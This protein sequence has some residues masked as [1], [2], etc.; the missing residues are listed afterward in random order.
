MLGRVR[1]ASVLVLA[2]V[3]GVCTSSIHIAAATPTGLVAAYSFDDGSGATAAD[4]SGNGNAAT[5]SGATWSPSGQ[6]GGAAQLNGTSALVRV[7][8]STSLDLSTGM[9]LEA[10]V[11]PTS[12]SASQT[13][14]AKE[15]AGGGFPYGLELDTVSPLPMRT[16]GRSAARVGRAPCRRTRGPSS[17][18]PSTAR[19]CASTSAPRSWRASRGADR[20]RSRT[21]GS[22][23]AAT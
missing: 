14:I 20:W 7:A 11:R 5:L 1:L 10:W 12:F 16:R 23:S 19:R 21:A 13:L 3:A 22:R 4:L 18:R 6:Y 9:T 17:P 15:R 2:A 8:D